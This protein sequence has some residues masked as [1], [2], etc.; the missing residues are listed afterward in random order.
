MSV[1]VYVNNGDVEAAL[2]KFKKAVD[3]DGVLRDMRN[4]EYFEKPSE[5]RK[6]EKNRKLKNIA[7]YQEEGESIF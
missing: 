2:R 6:R 3:R 4:R 7:K 5:K 1:K